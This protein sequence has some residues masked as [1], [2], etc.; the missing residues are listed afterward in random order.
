MAGFLFGAQPVPE[1]SFAEYESEQ[2]K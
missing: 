2:I 1:A